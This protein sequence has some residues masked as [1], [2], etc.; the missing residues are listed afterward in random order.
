MLATLE[1][2]AILAAM[3]ETGNDQLRAPA[4]LG[5]GKTTLYRKLQEYAFKSASARNF[6]VFLKSTESCATERKV[7]H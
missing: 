7:S 4:M 2:R 6:A 3:R 1:K 5:I